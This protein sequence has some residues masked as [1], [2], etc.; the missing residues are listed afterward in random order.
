MG[1]HASTAS[2][3]IAGKYVE[4]TFGIFPLS[5]FFKAGTGGKSRT[6]IKERIQAIVE[7]EDKAHPFSDDEI[8]A[9]LKEEG[10]TISRRTVAK[11][12][13]ELGVAG[14]NDRRGF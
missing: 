6:S 4:T 10:T 7:A 11:Y 3:T 5:Y 14:C 9:K 12:R 8:C 1:V 13:A 2:R